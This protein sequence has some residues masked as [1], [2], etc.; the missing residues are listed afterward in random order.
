[1][2]LGR[3][4]GISG[5]GDCQPP[6]DL[7]TAPHILRFGEFVNR[8]TLLARQILGSERLT[9]ARIDEYTDELRSLQDTVPELLQFKTSWLEETIELPEVPLSVKAAG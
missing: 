1:M 9:N 7:S 2:T 4:L 5:I 6:E 8:F 3:P